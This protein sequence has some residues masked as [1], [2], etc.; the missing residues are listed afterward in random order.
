MKPQAP[1]EILRKL[2]R[3]KVT[4][5]FHENCLT[6][7]N[8]TK[9]GDITLTGLTSFEIL[10]I[11]FRYNMNK[12]W[13]PLS[14]NYDRNKLKYISTIE[15]HEYPF[16]GVQFHPEK[17]IFEWATGSRGNIPHNRYNDE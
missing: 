5:N 1:E 4:I 14:Y 12:F 3:E 9:Y 2:T 17:N 8:F 15:A 11:Y 13:K 10:T 16:V 6:P 7:T